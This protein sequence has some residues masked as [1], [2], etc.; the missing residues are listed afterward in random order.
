MKKKEPKINKPLTMGVAKVP[1]VIQLEAME[2][3]AAC[4]CMVM[5]YYDKW[6]TLEQARMD[7]DV[8]RDGVN[9][10]S[11][12]KAARSYGFQAGGVRSDLENLK[13]EGQFPCIVFWNFNHFIVLDGYKNKKFYV[14][15]PARGAYPMSEEEFDK[16]F[17]GVVLNIKPTKDFEPGGQKPISMWKYATGRLKGAKME[18]ALVVVTTLIVSVLSVCNTAFNRIFMDRILTSMNPDW[19]YPLV[20]FMVGIAFLYIIASWI[21]VLYS[22]R[23][24]AKMDLSGSARFMWKVLHLPM[25][26]FSQRM[27]GDI[28]N[29]MQ[30]NSNIA[31]MTAMTVI[32]LLLN[33]V[34]MILY[35]VVILRY[36]VILTAI[37]VS[38]VLINMILG[39][40]IAKKK[41]DMAKVAS[42]ESAKVQGYTA[43]GIRMIETIKS[44]GAENGFFS[45]WSGA[46]A[47]NNAQ[48]IRMN[49]TNAILN[50][51]PDIVSSAASIFVTV[52]GVYFCISCRTIGSSGELFTAGAI[53]AFSGYMS[54]FTG[55][56][57]NLIGAG[58]S[59][60]GLRTQMERVDDVMKYPDDVCFEAESGSAREKLHGKVELKNVTFGYSRLKDPLIENFSLTVEQGERIAIVGP[61]GCGKSTLAALIAGLY[62]PWS[63][64][65]ELDGQEL[66]GIDR[67]VFTSSVAVVDQS[68]TLFQ[69]SVSENIKLWDK[70]IEDAKMRQ[71]AIDAQIHD[72]IS[73]RESGYFNTLHENGKNLSGGQRQRIEI[74]RA[75]ASDPTILILD[76]ATSALDAKTEG[77]VIRAINQRNITCIVVAHRL[78]AIR[79]CDRIIVLDNG[80]IVEEGN[81]EQL[82]AKKGYYSKLVIAE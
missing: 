6:I 42:S 56:A 11:I 78:S 71:A 70:T 76:E 29:R 7:C 31:K 61:S 60:Q 72:E 22:T 59:I 10:L 44:A 14:N 77:D 37:G 46:Q 1:V 3:G 13:K 17:T 51:L 2:C 20:L 54:M 81:H 15:D 38:A 45:V 39:Y 27:S 35:L 74:A 53:V 8:T 36:S 30:Q 34:M 69:G 68:I 52:I 9:A 41:V 79:D 12:V 58:Q 33:T 4:L 64:R 19:L 21:N 40:F 55:P 50:T 16:G 65:I 47:A 32:P 28:Q 26:F 18:I 63:G 66:S 48:N 73:G 49:R 24:N 23:I 5:S 67:D 43:L 80:K 62:R 75:L 82:M 25:R 57:Q